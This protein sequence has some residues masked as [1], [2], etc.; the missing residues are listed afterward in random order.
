M[1][2]TYDVK[3]PS[4]RPARAVYAN[5]FRDFYES[6]H[7]SACISYGDE[8]EA[9][10]AQKSMCMLVSREGIYDLVIKTRKNLLYLSRRKE[11]SE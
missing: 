4:P 8:K 5:V 11:G 10:R 7:E 2:I 1:E 3:I 6:D 9:F